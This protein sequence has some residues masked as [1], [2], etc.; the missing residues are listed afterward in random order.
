MS[1]QKKPFGKL[2][3]GSPVTLFTLRN[4]GRL[5][6][7]VMNYGAT[8]VS[9]EAPDR[10]GRPAD[11]VLGFDTLE[12]YVTRNGPYFGCIV[13]RYANRIA[14]GR[15]TM[16]GVSYKLATNN[17]PNHLHG[18]L[19]GFDKVYWQAEASEGREPSVK[20][21]YLSRDGEEGYPGNLLVTVVYTLTD[22]NELR[23]KY[24]AKTDK[25]TPVNLTNHAYFNLAGTGDVLAHELTITG[26]RYL[27]V[28]DT[29]IP[30]GEIRPVKGTPMDFTRPMG[31]GSRFAELGGDPGGYDHCYV[32]QNDGRK[33]ALAAHIHDP[34]S[35][36]ILEVHT[37]EPGMQLYTGNFL[38]DS[39]KGKGGHAYPRHA[40]FCLET[41]HFPDSVNQ[42]KFP[43]VILRPGQGYS[44]KTSFRFG[45]E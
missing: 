37:T 29:L 28:D 27:P 3:D 35:G 6:A 45:V 30:T 39:I 32:L 7:A 17:G 34:E 11:I 25:A 12:D 31:I 21:T 13:G 18:G 42:P 10:K 15:F 38:D 40:G 24:T 2:A 41:Q 8:L 5:K 44:Q 9:L 26:D 14:K 33:P 22:Q 23:I 1:L 20:F 16:D 19:K 43:S 4:A 36:R